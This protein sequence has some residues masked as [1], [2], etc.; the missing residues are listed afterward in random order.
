MDG[1]FAPHSHTERV[2][3]IFIDRGAPLRYRSFRM[4]GLSAAVANSP[5]SQLGGCIED[6][7]DDFVVA[8]APAEVAGEPVAQRGTQAS[9]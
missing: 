7:A 3:P 1:H 8:G 4:H 9:A 5:A 2:A 6:G